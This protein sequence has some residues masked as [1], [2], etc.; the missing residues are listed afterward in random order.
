MM[1]HWLWLLAFAAAT[2]SAAEVTIIRP[3]S[4]IADDWPLYVFFDEQKNPVAD[5]L[6]AERVTLQVPATT[7]SLL[8]KCSKGLGANYDEVRLDFDFRTHERAFFVLTPRPTCVQIDAVD[9]ATAKPL[10][11]E[12]R[13]RLTG[14]LIEYDEPKAAA[15]AVGTIA[16]TA[17]LTAVDSAAKD[18]INAATAAWVDAFNKRDAARLAALYDPDAVLTDAA[19]AQPRMGTTAIGD[20]YKQTAKRTTQRVALGERS[21]RVLG[22]TAIDSGTLT[23]FEMRD[24]NATTSPGR[25]SFTYQKRGGKW[26]I[27]DHQTSVPR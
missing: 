4:Y 18:Q 1:H 24:G 6:N 5:L 12:T 13:H 17:A 25:Y 8:I 3:K 9:A 20:Y 11:R 14:R 26:L 21:V 2:A 22:D 23:Y 7:R 15:Q 19:E 16:S 27:V 10:V